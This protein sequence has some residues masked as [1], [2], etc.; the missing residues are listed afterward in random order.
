M[1]FVTLSICFNIALNQLIAIERKTST[2]QVD[3]ALFSIGRRFPSFRLTPE[4]K[5]AAKKQLL[6][7]KPQPPEVSKQSADDSRQEP[8]TDKAA[9]VEPVGSSARPVAAIYGTVT[10]HLSQLD[11]NASLKSQEGGN[12]YENGHIVLQ[13]KKKLEKKSRRNSDVLRCF[14]GRR[15]ATSKTTS[16][17]LCSIIV[18]S[19]ITF[20]VAGSLLLYQSCKCKKSPGHLHL[21]EI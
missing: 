13:Q 14:G 10:K 20:L 18:L 11:L 21:K 8:E 16:R 12:I 5:K 1:D 9:I 4:Q 19:V 3:E 2:F 7:V 17:I 6:L 15:T